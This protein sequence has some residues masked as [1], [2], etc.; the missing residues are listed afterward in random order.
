MNDMHL[1]VFFYLHLSVYFS[2]LPLLIYFCIIHI[3]TTVF[4][5]QPLVVAGN[6]LCDLLV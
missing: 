5:M 6:S 3:R 1:S 4:D 2:T